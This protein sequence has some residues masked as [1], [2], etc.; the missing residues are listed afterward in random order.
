M[1]DRER[2]RPGR[3]PRPSTFADLWRELE[4]VGR[5]PRPAATA[6]TP[7]PRPTP[8]CRAWFTRQA[9]KR[10]LTVQ[11]DANGNLWAW[12]GPRGPGA[13]VTGSHLDSVPDGGGF[14]GALGVVTAL[15][16][17]DLLKEENFYP[18]RSVVLVA[19]TEEEG[20]RFGVR[21]WAAA[22]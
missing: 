5:D 1:A 2:C 10:G 12:W 20:A 18:E 6:A 11:P 22:C 17:V 8:H 9:E 4:P 15:A 13:V 3:P 16:A 21:A 7:G 14:D 19:F